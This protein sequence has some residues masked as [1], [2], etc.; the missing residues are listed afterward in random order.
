MRLLALSPSLLLLAV[1]GCDLK[2]NDT[3]ASAG[4]SAVDGDDSGD[5]GGGDDGTGDDGGGDDGGDDGGGDDG[6]GDDGGGDD[7]GG[8]DGGGDDGGGDDG[9]GDDGGGDTGVGEE[10]LCDDGTT[11]IP[12]DASASWSDMDNLAGDLTVETTEGEWTLSD[13]WTGCDSYLFLNL[14]NSSGYTYTDELLGSDLEEWLEASPRD[15]HYFFLSYEQTSSA[16][17]DDVEEAADQVEDALEDLDKELAEHWRDRI[18]FVTETAWTA[19]GLGTVLQNYGLWHVG[20]DRYQYLREVGL[21]YDAASSFNPY[22]LWLWGKEAEYYNFVVAR[23]EAMAAEEDVTVLRAFDAEYL[24]DGS[25]SGTRGSATVTFPDAKTMA[26]FD[27]MELDLTMEC[28]GHP[29]PEYCGEWDYLVYAYLCDADDP[30]TEEDESTSCP[31]LGRFITTYARPGRWVLD[32]TPYL[33]WLQ[34][35]GDRTVQFWTVQGY[36]ITLDIRLSNRGVGDRPYEIEYLWSGGTLN[37]QYNTN[38]EALVITPPEDATRAAIVATI[39]GHGYSSDAEY[40]GEFCNHE[41]HF[42]V[43]GGSTYTKDHPEASTAHG[44]A[45]TVSEGTVPNQW[46]TWVYGR[47]GWCPGLQVDQWVQDITADLTFGEENTLEY[48]VTIDGVEPYDTSTDGRIDMTS[49]IV[50]YK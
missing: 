22:A 1:L 10:E 38:H 19:G 3:A 2:T 24:S 34:D 15:V 21:M 26:T 37:D 50:Y 31:E 17:L 36:D 42:T 11:P 47:G 44:C 14:Y 35:G 29:E 23:D 46:G 13:H 27:T 16:I 20:I 6:G 9:G 8:D 18:H 12:F 33:A 28:T 41:N 7:G 4:D 48:S 45:E 32:V 25:W 5:D 40:C 43:N 49:Y 30:A 39:S